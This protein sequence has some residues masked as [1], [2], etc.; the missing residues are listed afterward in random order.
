MDPN[1]I[2]VQETALNGSPQ[3][4]QETLRIVNGTSNRTYPSAVCTAQQGSKGH[5]MLEARSVWIAG[6][7]KGHNT[8]PVYDLNTSP[9]QTK[10]RGLLNSSLQIGLEILRIVKGIQKGKYST[11]VRTAQ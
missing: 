4:G 1:Q 5:F 8:D 3:N 11:A 10:W 6:I 2:E 7:R 9:D